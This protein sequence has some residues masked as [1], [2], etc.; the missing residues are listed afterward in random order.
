MALLVKKDNRSLKGR[1][2]LPPSKSESARLLIIDAIL[3]TEDLA[4]ENL[5]DSTDS[6]T[7]KS[8]LES[9]L[10]LKGTNISL[11]LDIHD[12]GTAMRFITAYA[13][14]INVKTFIT[15]TGRMK[16][17]PLGILVDKL[18][19]L[20]SSI[21]YIEDE[22]YP[23]IRIEGKRLKGGEIEIDATVSS[24][25]ISALLLVAPKMLHG[26]KI[27]LLGEVISAPYIDMTLKVMREFGIEIERKE[28]IISIR[29]QRYQNKKVYRIESDWSAASYWYQMAAFADEVDL[30]LLGLKQKS[31]QG[32]SIIAEWASEFGVQTS[33]TE[34][35]VHLTKVKCETTS[36]KKDF[37][38][39]P[40]L[41]Q[42]LITT[43]A[44][45]QMRGD[46]TGLKTLRL[47]ETDRVS[48]LVNE[49][50]ALN[51]NISVDNNKM[52]LLPAK[53]V[54]KDKVKVYADHRMAMSFAPL[55][56]IL[57]QL[58]IDS[59]SVVAKSYPNFWGDLK[60]VGFEL[61]EV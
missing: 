34:E 22:G 45:L 19:E 2:Q 17:R 60:S 31:T 36:I 7:L 13:A 4:I 30:T 61:T 35:G 39:N 37:H 58:V 57:G 12:S 6:T 16:Q 18:K 53:L 49:L 40:D 24:Q 54:V 9:L 27:K 48:A 52:K 41:A 20:G 43:T 14:G 32:D 47:K 29:K 21:T 46:F 42:T 15:G 33:F 23:P 28:N 56:I 26:L 44:G 51:V 11:N 8:S 3:G 1:I 25:F 10:R 5:S 50:G 59:P 55:S 38:N